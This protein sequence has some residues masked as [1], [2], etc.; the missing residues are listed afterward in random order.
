[1]QKSREK[2]YRYTPSQYKWKICPVY[3]DFKYIMRQCKNDFQNNNCTHFRGIA[4]ARGWC[5]YYI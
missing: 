2:T 4:F 5:F 3:Q 1:M